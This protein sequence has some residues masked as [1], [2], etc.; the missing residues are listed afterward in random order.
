MLLL[1]FMSYTQVVYYGMKTLA[2]SIFILFNSSFTLCQELSTLEKLTER[3]NSLLKNINSILVYYNTLDGK[4]DDD[5]SPTI[6]TLKEKIHYKI[7]SLKIIDGVTDVQF[8][9]SLRFS[10]SKYNSPVD[11]EY[12]GSIKCQVF[13]EVK[14]IN[15]E[16]EYT[17]TAIVW[18]Y[19][20][21]FYTYYDKDGRIKQFDQIVSKIIDEF[22]LKY[23]KSNFKK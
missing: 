2:M 22:A 11:N 8:D 1:T 14:V 23:Y 10:F 6:E 15:S 13:R 18:D 4:E 16:S 21:E 20:Y 19:C 3:E 12:Y 7:P 9:T 17:P 5:E